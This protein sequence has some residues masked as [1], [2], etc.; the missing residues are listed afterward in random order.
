MAN[1]YEKQI[2]DEPG[3]VIQ[4]IDPKDDAAAKMQRQA[5]QFERKGVANYSQQ[6]RTDAGVM[7]N[8]V[9]AKHADDPDELEKALGDIRKGVLG[10]ITRPDV[11]AD[12]LS[13]YDLKSSS[14]VARARVARENT[15]RKETKST[16]SDALTSNLGDLQDAAYGIFS[17]DDEDIKVGYMHAR[18]GAQNA[19]NAKHNNG[20]NV[21][22]DA[23]R[24]SAGRNMSK[25]SLVGL[26]TFL[27]D[28]TGDD[29]RKA[30]IIR[31][32]NAGEYKDMFD[33]EDYQ[34]AMRL[35]KA[36]AR[37]TGGSGSSAEKEGET[38]AYVALDAELMAFNDEKS[39]KPATKGS[40][41]DMLG[42]RQRAVDAFDAGQINTKEYNKL[43]SNTAERALD[44][45]EDFRGSG[46]FDWKHITPQKYGI[47]KIG[48]ALD[49]TN[50]SADERL[51][52][53]E[54]FMTEF[55]QQNAPT[56]RSSESDKIA[57]KIADDVINRFVSY[58]YPGF[59]PKTASA[60]VMGRTAYRMPGSVG[61][62]VQG[63]VITAEVDE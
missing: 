6:L 11:A 50:F 12:F 41:E 7:M 54:E 26:Q 58:K 57:G 44:R 1:I 5:E 55:A 47:R 39:G 3:Q 36:A 52:V 56:E 43:M 63:G 2:L 20:L 29:T 59:N 35:I 14:L 19:I 9:F 46:M 51:A 13:D 28:P 10:T 31:R 23:E 37:Q 38:L 49:K 21:F 4:G 22:T 62:P 24:K 60:V 40:L 48:D 25:S 17:A 61:K 16:M 42:L 34:K 32:F 18:A 8:D 30:E 53:Y 27:T 45:F 15:Q 33:A